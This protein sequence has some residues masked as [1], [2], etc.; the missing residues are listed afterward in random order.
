MI[1][2]ELLNVE[3]AGSCDCVQSLAMKY[4]ELLRLR[5]KVLDAEALTATARP[6]AKTSRARKNGMIFG[7]SH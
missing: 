7:R 1:S 6:P 2:K 3:E 4:A 5:R